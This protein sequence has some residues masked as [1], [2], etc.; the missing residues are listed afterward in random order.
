MKKVIRGNFSGEPKIMNMYEIIL[1]I[2]DQRGPASIPSICQQVNQD[3]IFMKKRDKPV[4]QAQVK[5]VIS[6]KKDLFS[7]HNDVV[8]LLPEKHFISLTAEVGECQ[9]PF[10]K[11]KV[12]FIKK[13]F[14]FFEINLDPSK[15]LEYQPVEPGSTD[16]FKQELYRLKI[17]NWDSNYEQDGI[18]LDG[19][20]WS[21]RLETRAQIF[22]SEGLQ[23][24]PKEWTKLCRAL[25]KLT[26]R[27]FA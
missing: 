5:S 8:S 9:G 27:K 23:S 24:F 2:I 14:I 21:I 19:T 10:F 20:C 25:S 3:P 16:E 13:T 22:R 17:W 1:S 15:Q 6:R 18:V 26:G 11:V 4:Q 12:D 7:V